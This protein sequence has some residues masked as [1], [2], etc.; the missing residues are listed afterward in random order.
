[1]TKYDIPTIFIYFD[2]MINNKK[3][4]FN[5]INIFLMKKIL[6]LISFLSYMMK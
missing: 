5:K 4:L 6:I 2:K 1:M 3:Y